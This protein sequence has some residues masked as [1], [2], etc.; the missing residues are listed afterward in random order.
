M[1]INNNLPDKEFIEPVNSSQL[2]YKDNSEEDIPV[3]KVIDNSSTR[4]QQCTLNKTL[5]LKDMPKLWDKSM[6]NKDPNMSH[7]DNII[8][9]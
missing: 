8:N 6:N 4:N 9:V 5:A 3:S 7:I 1:E 2:S